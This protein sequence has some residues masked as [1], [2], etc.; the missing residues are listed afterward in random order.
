M[1]VILPPKPPE[2]PGP[3]PGCFSDLPPIIWVS[4]YG[5]TFLICAGQLDNHGDGIFSGIA[6]CIAGD[7]PFITITV[8]FC[9]DE[10]GLAGVSAN[11]FPGLFCGGCGLTDIW[12]GGFSCWTTSGCSYSVSVW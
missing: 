8:I 2:P 12:C 9:V 4:L 3:C 10:D 7:D 11:G 1:G 5:P 6:D